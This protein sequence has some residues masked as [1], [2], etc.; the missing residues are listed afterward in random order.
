MPSGKLLIKM[1]R[2]QNASIKVQR[3]YCQAPVAHDYNPSYSRSRD[4]EDFRLRTAQAKSEPL[5]K[6]EKPNTKKT[7]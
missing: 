2:F 5:S 1:M 4:Q 7:G 3:R 6:K